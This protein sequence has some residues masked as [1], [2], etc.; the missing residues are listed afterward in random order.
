MQERHAR[1]KNS[2]LL[3]TFVNYD[4]KNKKFDNI[5]PCSMKFFLVR[6]LTLLTASR[7]EKAKFLVSVENMS[8]V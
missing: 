2:S 8:G 1:E 4:L 5:G 6:I 7:R 3:P